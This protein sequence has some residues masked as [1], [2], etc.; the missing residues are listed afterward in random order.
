LSSSTLAFVSPFFAGCGGDAVGPRPDGPRLSARPGTPLISAPT[1]ENELSLDEP[2]QDGFLY[3]PT[4][5]S[6]DTSLPLLVMLHGAS[7]SAAGL[8]ALFTWG[9]AH[10]FGVLLPDARSRTWDRITYGKDVDFL[11]LALEHVFDRWLIDPARL[12]FA[13]FSDGAS[14]ALSLGVSNGDLFSHLI[15]FS[16]GWFDPSSP[17]IGKPRVF[18]SHGSPTS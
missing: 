2:G 17:V 12:A 4:T 10:G 1:G 14:Y 16:P 3:V 5:H 8:K 15:G 11:D 6:Q 9:E 13:G 7:D 18:I